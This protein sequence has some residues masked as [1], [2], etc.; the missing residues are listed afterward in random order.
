MARSKAD[1]LIDAA[2][3]KSITTAYSSW[4][5]SSPTT[6]MQLQ[7]GVDFNCFAI[8]TVRKL[9]NENRKDVLAI[10]AE[11]EALTFT[12]KTL[13]KKLLKIL[14]EEEKSI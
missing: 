3:A 14:E 8:N 9:Y 13:S 11:P 10:L 2:I 12:L 1:I 4:I 5:G 6:I 7:K